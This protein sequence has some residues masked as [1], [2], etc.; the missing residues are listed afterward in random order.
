VNDANTGMSDTKQGT[1]TIFSGG[2]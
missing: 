2:L 1:V